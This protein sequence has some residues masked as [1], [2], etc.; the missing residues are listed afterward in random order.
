MQAIQQNHSKNTVQYSSFTKMIFEFYLLTEKLYTTE[1]RQ[2]D[3]LG[4]WGA[5]LKAFEGQVHGSIDKLDRSLK[6]R[7]RIMKIESSRETWTK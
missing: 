6:I 3:L 7:A 4:S 2:T 5:S 1:V